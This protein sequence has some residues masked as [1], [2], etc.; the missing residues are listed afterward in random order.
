MSGISSLER[1]IILTGCLAGALSFHLY[2]QWRFYPWEKIFGDQQLR[3]LI[4]MIL[5]ITF[6]LFLS[7][8]HLNIMNPA[9]RGEH[10]LWMA[11]SAQ[12][13][14]GFA[15][16]PI[17]D[18]GQTALGILSISMFIGGGLGSTAGGIKLLRLMILLRIFQFYLQRL[19]AS[20][21]ASIPERFMGA[22]LT[23]SDIQSAV[24]VFFTYIMILLVSW[25]AFLQ[26]GH[27]PMAALFEVSSALGT[28]GLSSGLTGPDLETDLKV[29]LAI[30][31]LMGRVEA[32]AII[33]LFFPNSWFGKR[34]EIK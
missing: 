12:T 10:A 29:V 9:Q 22:T 3:F 8:S 25:F 11:I 4:A 13:T 20:A 6:L 27:E 23:S 7:M 19:S 14:A 2:Y 16:M 31:M 18:M 32:I 24:T 34:K 5:L 21:H 26:Y 33:I 30:N 15:T 17:K 28:A 1:G